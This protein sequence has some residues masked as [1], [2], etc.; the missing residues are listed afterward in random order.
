[1]TINKRIY[2]MAFALLPL[3]ATAQMLTDGIFM[4]KKSICGGVMLMQDKF[5]EYWEGTKLRTN[6]NMGTMSMTA[7]AAMATYGITDRL[8][9]S[10]SAPYIKTKADAGVMT[11][12]SGVQD[13]TLG[14]KYNILKIKDLAV[15]AIAGGSLPL[16]NYVAA[17]P[18]AIGTQSKTLFGRGMVH[19]LH[20]K[21]WT[22]SAQATYILRSN[23]T[24]DQ[25]NYYT[26]Q[27]VFSNKVEMDN[28]FQAGVRG[29][30]Y[31]YRWATEVTF[32][33][34]KVLGGFDIRRNDMMFPANK[35]EA[36]RLGLLASYRIKPLHDLQVVGNVAY[37]LSGR[38][39]GKALTLG[40]GLMMA[41]DF[42]KKEADS[43]KN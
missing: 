35:Q 18:L 3:F 1:M 21:G 37:T 39:V 5:D 29:G 33:Q 16:S 28:I 7:I 40:V 11:E 32:D 10:I 6:A 14:L 17:Y 4:P 13:L 15:N 30:F 23:I 9:V 22:F 38:N 26:D 12:M 19:Y 43:I 41:F 24:I 27:N 36:T 42:K 20:Q 2:A 25:T 34:S 31:S 8:N